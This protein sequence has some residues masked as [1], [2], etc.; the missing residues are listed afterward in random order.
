MSLA[1]SE[2]APASAAAGVSGGNPPLAPPPHATA[3]ANVV[4]PGDG[5]LWS[6][7]LDSVKSTKAVQSKQ[8]IVVGAPHAGKSSLVARLRAPDGQLPLDFT[9]DGPPAPGKG[10]ALDLG[11]SYQVMD[12]RDEGEE[13]DLLGRLGFYQISTSEP[14][15]SRLAS[16]ALSRC[17]LADSLVMLVLDWQKPWTFVRELEG[18]I[19]TLERALKV[20][21]GEE[22]SEAAEEDQVDEGRQRLE[23]TWRA[24][25]EPTP[26][27][28]MPST[29]SAN[30]HTADAPLPAG[31]LL[32]NLGLNLVVVCTKADQMDM[33]ER[34]REFSEDKFDYVQQLVRTIAMRFGAAVFYTSQ[35]APQSYTKLRQYMLH[36]LFSPPPASARASFPFL[37]RANVVDRDQ[38]LVPTGWD[39]WGKIRI[40]RE[41]FDCE[42][43][44]Q[45]W[46]ADLDA[47][48]RRREREAQGSEAGEGTEPAGLRAD[49]EAIVTDIHAHNKTQAPSRVTEAENEQAFLRQHYEVLQ[50]EV[51]KD[52]RLAFRQPA[53][54]TMSSS[55]FGPSAVGPMA[56]STLDLPTVASTLDRARGAAGGST[57]RDSL[58]ARS[59][60]DRYRTGMSRQN[61]SSSQPARSPQLGSS[62]SPTHPSAASFLSRTPSQQ[63]AAS[64]TSTSTMPTT[65]GSGTAGNAAG[66]NQ[67]LADFFQSLLTAR[68]ASSSPNG[69][70]GG[71]AAG[72]ASNLRGS[73]RDA[74]P[75]E[76]ARRE[77]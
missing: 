24:Y 31:A 23:A 17:A 14:P 63:S 47:R 72:A 38:I 48:R 4:L 1:A 46:D 9:T 5:G 34:D 73:V 62:T 43:C 19:E 12:V 65:P 7:I 74:R 26:N 51:A 66:G 61:S 8:C 16:L 57:T 40:L 21:A 68:T 67:V 36:R 75:A 56:G 54:G 52:P 10:K 28:T 13:G 69:P 27:G 22:G 53:A 59:A 44:G 42:A 20:K 29:S 3:N 15:R 64:G 2:S 25:Q 50:A 6:S 70:Q 77:G 45:S 71:S 33:L 32:E 41:R 11:I 55:G 49:Y 76:E 35:T 60:E 58:S 37:H 39:T 30:L 18:W